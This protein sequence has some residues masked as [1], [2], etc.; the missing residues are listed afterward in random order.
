MVL[1]VAVS[2]AR[3][4]GKK[5]IHNITSPCSLGSSLT[6]ATRERHTGGAV[7]SL[8]TADAV[9]PLVLHTA[10]NMFWFF[11]QSNQTSI[12]NGS[13]RSAG[14]DDGRIIQGETKREISIRCCGITAAL[15]KETE[16]RST[17]LHDHC[18]AS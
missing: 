14:G 7:R 17:R 5:E 18:G 13:L 3:K 1:E 11:L 10:K 8:W 16:G 2:M 6:E 4:E 9:M 12:T 15:H